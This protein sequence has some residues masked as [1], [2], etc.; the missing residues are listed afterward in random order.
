MTAHPNPEDAS[1]L[2]TAFIKDKNVKE[3]SF[4]YILNSLSGITSS[5]YSFLLI[6]S[7]IALKSAWIVN[8]PAKN[9]QVQVSIFLVYLLLVSIL[10][11]LYIF[12]YLTRSSSQDPRTWLNHKSH[13]NVFLRQ[14]AIVFGLG[15]LV[16]A[17]LEF[18]SGPCKDYYHSIV[19]MSFFIFT[20]LQVIAIVRYPR[21]NICKF[22][23]IA[24][25]GLMHLVTTNAIIWIHTVVKESVHELVEAEERELGLHHHH[26]DRV[27]NKSCLDD[28]LMRLVEDH[29]GDCREEDHFDNFLGDALTKASPFLFAFIIEFSLIGATV[30]YATWLHV[31]PPQYEAAVKKKIDYSLAE[32]PNPKSFFFKID[33]SHSLFGF[34]LGIFIAFINLANLGI[35]FFMTSIDHTGDEFI[36]N[37]TNTILNI[38]GTIAC[39]SGLVQIQ[40]LGHKKD[41]DENGFDLSM[42][43]IGGFFMYFYACLTT[44]VGFN[45]T[46]IKE[47]SS[48]LIVT[49][50]ILEILYVTLQVTF[51]TNLLQ[52]TSTGGIAK[53]CSNSCSL[54]YDGC[55]PGRQALM[56]LTI[57]NISQWIIATFELQKS[58]ASPWERTFYGFLPWIILQRISLPLCIFF[59]FHSA[60]IAIDCWKNAYKLNVEN[61]NI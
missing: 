16:Y 6:A 21:L 54:L 60:V 46:D 26:H 29:H 2:N 20:I 42:L 7:F 34:L 5:L 40:K 36:R 33:W 43:N 4:H 25:F 50:G 18:T 51:L 1:P 55:K 23:V 58:L 35:F 19:Y 44:V 17:T 3:E 8:F 49:N 47:A 31:G 14:G 10:F 56:F 59:R 41:K 9:H 12:C 15:T 22:P 52:K 38:L 30:F 37:I 39:M 57:L 48:E 13:G 11:L 24:K 27:V 32:I 45:A 28:Y 61:N 53:A